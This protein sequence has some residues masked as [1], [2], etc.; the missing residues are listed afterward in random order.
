MYVFIIQAIKKYF[1]FFF[2]FNITVQRMFCVISVIY[3]AE[4][5]R[6][7]TKKFIKPI[8]FQFN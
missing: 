6:E 4:I 8:K 5:G 7:M 2:H 3:E 1:D